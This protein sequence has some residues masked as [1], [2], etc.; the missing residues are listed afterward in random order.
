MS[1][2]SKLRAPLVAGLALLSLSAAA[3]SDRTFT[4][5]YTARIAAPPAGQPLDLFL[6]L[7]PQNEAQ[8]IVALKVEGPIKGLEATEPRFGNRYWHGHLDSSDGTPIEMAVVAT[9]KRKTVKGPLGEPGPDEYTAEEKARLQKF[10]APDEKVPLKGGPIDKIDAEL[11][12]KLGA[13]AADPAVAA[14]AI[15]DYVV[16]HM[17]Y[18]KVGTGWGNGD[19]F[20]ACSAKYGNCTDFHALFLSLARRRG[21]PARFEMGFP[22]PLEMKDGKIPGYHCWVEFWLP[23]RGWVPV[24]A[25]E[26]WKHPEQ[27][28]LLFGGQPPDRV[29]LSEGRDLNL[30]GMH[31][32]PLNY[33]IYPHL[34][35]AGEPSKLVAWELTFHE[36]KPAL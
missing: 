13:K 17:E 4:F 1:F 11:T 27:R 3:T 9:V 20:W 16:D 7:P 32:P 24:D 19:T 29:Q 18:K 30:S 10:L 5:R 22:L 25:S 6:P 2:A 21:I 14:R 31:G 33:F 23:G 35:V 26:A 28:E 34:E 15:Y 36:L 8:E 12:A